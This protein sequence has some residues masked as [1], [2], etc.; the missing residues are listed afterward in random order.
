MICMILNI[1]K[2]ILFVRVKM[3]RFQLEFIKK[4]YLVENDLSSQ[5][6]F[7]LN[8]GIEIGVWCFIF[9]FIFQKLNFIFFCN[10]VIEKKSETKQLIYLHQVLL[11]SPWIVTINFIQIRHSRR[12]SHK[13]YGPSNKTFFKGWET[14]IC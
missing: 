7:I 12:R 13:C 8:S 4:K 2:I 11:D 14:K 1:G 6:K 3:Q 5:E 10:L 9:L